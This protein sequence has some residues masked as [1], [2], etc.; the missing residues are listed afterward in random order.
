LKQEDFYIWLVLVAG[1]LW[2]PVFRIMISYVFGPLLN[3]VIFPSFQTG[4]SGVI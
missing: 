2:Y 1:F 3:N 4:I